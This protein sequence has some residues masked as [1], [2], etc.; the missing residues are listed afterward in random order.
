VQNAYNIADRESDDVLDACTRD[1]LGFLP[2]RPLRLRAA[3]A[4]DERLQAVAARQDATP[5]QIA[6]AWLLRRS[7]AMLPIP[8][9]GS[10]AH[11]EENAGA[12]RLR[13]TE[14]DYRSLSAA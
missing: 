13:L 6:L 1:G 11:L 8:G 14:E 2:W 4:L 3:H 10:T 9:T 5:A 7:P 12:A